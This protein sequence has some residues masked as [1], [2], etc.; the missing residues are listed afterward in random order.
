MNGGGRIG[1][2]HMFVHKSLVKYLP[3]VSVKA[4][5]QAAPL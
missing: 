4:Y 3:Y 1:V 5:N 2:R